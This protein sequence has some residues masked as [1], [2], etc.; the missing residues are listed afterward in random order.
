MSAGHDRRAPLRRRRKRRRTVLRRIA[1]RPGFVVS[2][3]FDKQ[4]PSP[5]DEEEEGEWRGEENRKRRAAQNGHASRTQLCYNVRAAGPIY[6]PRRAR[7][8][9]RC[10][11]IPDLDR[12]EKKPKN[13]RKPKEPKGSNCRHGGNFETQ[14]RMRRDEIARARE[15]DTGRRLKGERASKIISRRKSEIY[16]DLSRYRGIR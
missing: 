2:R 14:N 4:K 3:I 11:S 12:G 15:R 5:K 1:A 7:A 10:S 6:T 8:H 16:R 9:A 13:R